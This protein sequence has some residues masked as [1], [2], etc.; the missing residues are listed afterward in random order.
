[1]LVVAA[2]WKAWW[3]HSTTMVSFADAPLIASFSAL[4]SS[5]KALFHTALFVRETLNLNAKPL[6]LHRR[7]SCGR[8]KKLKKVKKSI[9]VIILNRYKLIIYTGFKVNWYKIKDFFIHVSII[10]CVKLLYL[11]IIFTISLFI[12][13]FIVTGIKKFFIFIKLPSHH[14][15]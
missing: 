11:F 1:M 13:D 5:S 4:N 6:S 7:K 15:L 2:F 8:Q 9:H 3:W 12:P 10:I 14:F